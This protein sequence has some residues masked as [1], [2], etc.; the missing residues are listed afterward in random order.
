MRTSKEKKTFVMICILACANTALYGLPYM[1]SQFYDVMLEV[2][3]LNH[4]QLSMLFSING[5]VCMAA[6]IFGGI[7]TD[8]FSVKKLMVGALIASGIMHLY[9]VTV[10]SYP[11][12]CVIYAMLA[13]TSVLIFYP[14][15]MKTLTYLGGEGKQ[16]SVFG[17]YIAAIDIIGILV[18]GIGLLAMMLTNKSVIVFR[19]IIFLYGALH[20]IAAFYLWKFFEEKEYQSGDNRI[21]V[22]EILRIITD[23]KI[24]VVIFIIF[25]NYLMMS[26][27]TYVI[28]YLS[29]MYGVKEQ[30]IIILSIVRVNLI[31]IVAGPF[32]GKI[33]DKIGSAIQLMKVTFIIST[34]LILG[35]LASF[36]FELSVG[37]V[38]V[39]ILLITLMIVSAKSL[40]LVMLSEIKVPATYMGTAIGIVSFLGYSPD[41]FFYSFAGMAIDHYQIKGYE[42]I[43]IAF[44]VC[45][46]IGAMASYFLT[47]MLSKENAVQ[48]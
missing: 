31:A 10:P 19:V 4:T 30:N 23:K 9:V 46:V 40:N 22:G 47:R 18:V 1:K 24:W 39:I 17:Y 7:I 35:I 12:L 13:V 45:S 32:A 33:V 37:I 43:F 42:Y 14:A 15:S 11:V 25:S 29:Q 21:K 20:F 6:Y 2:L 8:Y 28:P 5:M 41:A 34:I 44:L 36:Y 3:H 38:I 48:K 26:A 27:M 16:G